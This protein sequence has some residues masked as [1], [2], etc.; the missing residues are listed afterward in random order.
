[1]SAEHSRWDNSSVNTSSLLEEYGITLSQTKSQTKTRDTVINALSSNV[2]EKCS[3]IDK[4]I[5]NAYVKRMTEDVLK[6]E[7]KTNKEKEYYQL[8]EQFITEQVEYFAQRD[9][10]VTYHY[11]ADGRYLSQELAL[12]SKDHKPENIL[13][14][15]KLGQAY[16]KI[17]KEH[18]YIDWVEVKIK[19]REVFAKNPIRIGKSAIDESI[20]RYTELKSLLTSGKDKEAKQKKAQAEYINKGYCE[21]YGEYILDYLSRQSPEQSDV[22]D[23][24]GS[25]P[26][27]SQ[28]EHREQIS[29][30]I[31]DIL[32]EPVHRDIQYFTTC[33]WDNKNKKLSELAL[34][35]AVTEATN[36]LHWG[37]K[38]KELLTKDDETIANTKITKRMLQ[39]AIEGLVTDKQ[40]INTMAGIEDLQHQNKEKFETIIRA[41]AALKCIYDIVETPNQEAAS[42]KNANRNQQLM[43][44]LKYW[45]VL[46]NDDVKE[47]YRNSPILN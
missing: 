39:Q 17:K 31:N 12:L 46:G 21:F 2:K 3:S 47:I 36:V 14:K 13:K 30:L 33:T 44:K 1:M 43:N 4:K 18:P 41:S 40:A 34:Q 32:D 20:R 23:L 26:H 16:G 22:I 45:D 10:V 25:N 6:K 11:N 9:D 24:D 37:N 27:V 42:E 5:Q 19:A 35:Y 38:Q 29:D 15:L 8:W 28:T 7:I